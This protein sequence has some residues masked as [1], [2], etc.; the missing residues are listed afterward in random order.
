MS[1]NNIVYT[2]ETP[3]GV[4]LNDLLAKF[5]GVVNGPTVYELNQIHRKWTII[6]KLAKAGKLTGMKY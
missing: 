6:G 1:Q 3:Y 5:K 4:I 2:S